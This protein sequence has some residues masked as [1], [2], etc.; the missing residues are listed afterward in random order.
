MWNLSLLFHTCS[1]TVFVEDPDTVICYD[2]VLIYKFG[3]PSIFLEYKG[4]RTNRR[5]LPST[6]FIS[7]FRN[8]SL[9]F[10]ISVQLITVYNNLKM[11]IKL[12][13]ILAV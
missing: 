10:I 2:V 11:K 9:G 12:M 7:T 3:S 4:F 8:I 13:Y 5:P 6:G 1:F